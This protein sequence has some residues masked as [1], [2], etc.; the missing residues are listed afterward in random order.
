MNEAIAKLIAR[1]IA[2]T[3]IIPFLEGIFLPRGK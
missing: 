3:I 1:V 2:T